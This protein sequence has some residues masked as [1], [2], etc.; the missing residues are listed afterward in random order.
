MCALNIIRALLGHH[1]LDKR[2]LGV[3]DLDFLMYADSSTAFRNFIFYA[4]CPHAFS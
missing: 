2:V 4:F 1:L 3:R